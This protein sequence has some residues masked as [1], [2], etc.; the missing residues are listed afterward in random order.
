MASQLKIQIPP[1][2]PLNLGSDLRL[3][4]TR[5]RRSSNLSE[6]QQKLNAVVK[7]VV[8]ENKGLGEGD[9]TTSYEGDENDD[10]CSEYG[11]TKNHEAEAAAS[12]AGEIDIMTISSPSSYA[13]LASLNPYAANHQDLGEQISAA[14]LS[15]GVARED[16]FKEAMARLSWQLDCAHAAVIAEESAALQVL[17]HQTQLAS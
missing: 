17:R 3:S 1:I 4:V 9:A 6:L 11:E 8:G 15:N 14:V 12:K 7:R 16:E 13:D 2:H 5:G 10:T